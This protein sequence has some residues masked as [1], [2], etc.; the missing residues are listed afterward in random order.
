MGNSSSWNLENINL[1]SN[2]TE[3][4]LKEISIQLNQDVNFL[5]NLIKKYEPLELL[6][7][8]AFHVSDVKDLSK[9]NK[10]LHNE[11]M[12]NSQLEF[13]IKY[14]LSNNNNQGTSKNLAELS[15][16]KFNKLY[17]NFENHMIKYTDNLILSKNVLSNQ[18]SRIQ[19][20]FYSYM[21]PCPLYD[22]SS[23]D[24]KLKQLK[25]ILQPHV[26]S[27]NKTFSSGL[28]G[29]LEALES[30][31][32]I[33]IS[34]IPDLNKEF[35]MF[36]MKS[37]FKIEELRS[38]GSL[39]SNTE[40]LKQVIDEEQWTNWLRSL[41]QKAETFDLF[42]VNIITKLKSNDLEKLSL[43]LAS[44]KS[45]NFGYISES[46]GWD[47]SLFIEKNGS[48]YI[49]DGVFLFE[50][51][52][53]A[54]KKAVKLQFPEEEK[55]WDLT[56]EEKSGLLPISIFAGVFSHFDY[57]LGY[58]KEDTTFSA[59]FESAEKEVFIEVP[60]QHG[61]KIPLNPI[62][63]LE[64]TKIALQKY[65]EIFQH[66][67]SI[68]APIIVVDFDDKQIEDII[69]KNNI[70]S[71]T[72][73]YLVSLLNDWNEIRLF[74]DKI[75]GIR[76]LNIEVAESEI[77]NENKVSKTS[78]ASEID[79]GNNDEYSDLDSIDGDNCYSDED[80]EDDIDNQEYEGL[81]D[82]EN[83]EE[84]IESVEVDGEDEPELLGEFLDDE[85][86]EDSIISSEEDVDKGASN[87][88]S[89]VGFSLFDV[90]NNVSKGKNPLDN[91]ENVEDLEIS[92]NDS[93][94]DSKDDIFK[95]ELDECK[96]D[97]PLANKMK[98][99]KE[100]L[101]PVIQKKLGFSF[102]DVLNN[103][104]KGK[105]P[106]ENE[107]N[108]TSVSSVKINSDKEIKE[109][110]VVVFDEKLKDEVPLED[111]EVE[112]D[113]AIEITAEDE[114]DKLFNDYEVKSSSEKIPSDYKEP[115]LLIPNDISE[116]QMEDSLIEEE[117]LNIKGSIDSFELNN[118]DIAAINN[119]NAILDELDDDDS[120]LE[121][122]GLNDSLY[123]EDDENLYNVDEE[124]G[125]TNDYYDQLIDNDEDSSEDVFISPVYDRIKSL[126]IIKGFE[127]SIAKQEVQRY[128]EVKA[129]KEEVSSKVIEDE[130]NEKA[131]E[132][133][134]G[135]ENFSIVPPSFKTRDDIKIEEEVTSIESLWPLKIFN[136]IK[137]SENLEKSPFFN[138][139]KENDLELLEAINHLIEQALEQQ[140][141]DGKDKMFTIPN[142]TLTIILPTGT[143]DQLKK[144]QRMN[145][146]GSLM[147]SNDKESWDILTLNYKNQE[148]QDIKE[149]SISR[150]S[151]SDVDWKFVVTTGSRMKKNKNKV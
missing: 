64:L 138:I 67:G 36:S 38:K 96:V 63:D 11:E 70:Y 132:I 131:N 104:A 90:L 133:V 113:C 79:D 95:Q 105:D 87:N 32:K 98:D 23:I 117:L 127:K 126:E 53:K 51:A 40:L 89:L 73:S 74:R 72:Y 129:T 130:R 10:N 107:K 99:K 5:V 81:V 7:F 120:D 25:L 122:Y 151:Y 60:R 39:K 101:P 30:L 47:D 29:L 109:L 35:E 27:I 134:K 148:L 76:D 135:A 19:D 46:C 42:C 142:S 55:S 78:T 140:V 119:V 22:E 61:Y 54:I 18:R 9:K 111:L 44:Q 137:M 91:P 92:V 144:W 34:G 41:V 86:S 88:N 71:I 115:G 112:S 59:H 57:T 31:S 14:Y 118:S 147:Y 8:I 102:S 139:C 17:S 85:E 66:F 80:S 82:D 121:N 20:L 6:K 116:I 1:S 114:F 84:L 125:L 110:P 77:K 65:D 146:L 24:K 106:L 143:N 123:E 49:F 75:L 33:S 149:S 145:S 15:W 48:Y 141:I 3:R 13:I 103:V 37:E 43:S 69:Y 16:K 45:E 100:E 150:D 28:D 4:N 97:A 52:Y 50:K 56:E 124:S 94:N 12:A 108:D 58:E 128:M 68:S 62:K 136:I 93:L 21:F 2:K 83:T 26:S